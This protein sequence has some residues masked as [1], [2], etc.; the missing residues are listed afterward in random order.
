MRSFIVLAVGTIG[1]RFC[2]SHVATLSLATVIALLLIA[3]FAGP[4]LAGVISNSTFDGPPPSPSVTDQ[5]T[6]APVALCDWTANPWH[7]D[8]YGYGA[9]G[10]QADIGNFT[11]GL[12]F[13][14]AGMTDSSDWRTREGCDITKTVS[15]VGYTDIHLIYDLKAALAGLEFGNG[16][17][18]PNLHGD[19]SEQLAVQFSVD[20]GVT[21]ADAEWL[22]R[23][24]SAGYTGSSPNCVATGLDTYTSWGSRNVALP[25]T[26]ESLAALQLRFNWQFNGSVDYGYLDNIVVTGS[27][28]PEP[29]SL[30][31]LLT[32]LGGLGGILRM[33]RCWL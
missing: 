21:W 30:L 16:V 20:N 2:I 3:E 13:H 32:G 22:R 17:Y 11:G 24:G 27:P 4:S 7:S 28:V 29:S 26:C 23:G 9:A 8:A 31:A 12:E 15:T 1:K 25:V 33:K 5:T 19:L 18:S 14:G 6:G 10:W